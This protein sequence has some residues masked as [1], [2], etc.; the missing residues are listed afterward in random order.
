[1]II[2]VNVNFDPCD[3]TALLL[4]FYETY[5]LVLVSVYVLTQETSALEVTKIM[6]STKATSY[7]YKLSRIKSD[8]NILHLIEAICDVKIPFSFMLK[9]TFDKSYCARRSHG[10]QRN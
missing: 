9:I 7:K 4:S 6:L 1:M 10:G 8:G 5:A 3:P 2:D